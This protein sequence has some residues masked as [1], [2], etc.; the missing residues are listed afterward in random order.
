[1]ERTWTTYCGTLSWLRPTMDERRGHRVER[2]FRKDD[3]AIDHVDRW[4][5][6]DDLASHWADRRS[7]MDDL[8]SFRVDRWARMDDSGFLRVDR[9]ARADD[10][11]SHR[12]DRRSRMDD[13]GPYRVDRRS[14][15]VDLGSHHVDLGFR[16][17]DSALTAFEGPGFALSA[18]AATSPT[19]GCRRGRL[20]LAAAFPPCG[21]SCASRAPVQVGRRGRRQAVA[22]LASAPASADSHPAG[23]QEESA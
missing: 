17:D 9:R 5:R 7:R 13:L 3:L 2:P 4:F 20:A 8:A 19:Q 23:A 22:P 14:R 1:M 18:L 10:L 15:M 16:M 6:M 21:V 11:G 12:V